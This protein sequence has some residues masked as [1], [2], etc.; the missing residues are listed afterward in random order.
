MDGI[1]A[2]A[3]RGQ[4]FYRPELDCLRFFAFF[5]VYVCHTLPSSESFYTDHHVLPHL[6]TLLAAIS[7]A[8][9]IAG[10]DLFFVLSA[11]LITSLLLREQARAGRLHLKSF[12]VRRILRIWPLYFV[13]LGI[14]V[15]WHW[16]QPSVYMPGDYLLAYLLLSGNW[17]TSFYGPPP[18][19]MSILWS[20]SIEEQF[21]LSWPLVLRF[22]RK[23]VLLMTAVT[24]WVAALMT[25]LYLARQP[26]HEY[27][28][29]PNTLARLD[30]FAWGILA[31]VVLRDV[32]QF[33]RGKRIAL[34]GL[35]AGVWLLCGHYF[36]VNFNFTVLGFAA[37]S[38]GSFAIFLA[39][40]GSNF[41]HPALVYLG[42][43]SYGLYVYHLFCLYLSALLYHGK[44][45]HAAW[46][47]LHWV[48]ALLLTVLI[49]SASYSW[50]EAPFLRLKDSFTYVRSRPV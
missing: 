50:L 28:I 16:F 26:I 35:G 6:A 11:Y 42:K 13:A 46:F 43:I 5:A 47:G 48:T 4:R 32:P 37:V 18:S 9:G 12:Y 27:T 25:R 41:T 33:S 49:A 40:L 36:S 29:F 19:F 38:M 7:R 24:L 45:N 23:K 14:A 39:F 2:C 1:S 34:L 44:T 22:S 3:S 30:P 17:M 31:A 15:V 20:V 8:C 10:V 21:Y